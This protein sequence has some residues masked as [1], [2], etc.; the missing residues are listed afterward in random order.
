[1]L[2]NVTAFANQPLLLAAVLIGGLLGMAVE[3]ALARARRRAWPER[4]RWRHAPEHGLAEDTQRTPRLQ[5]RF[6]KFT[7]LA[8][9]LTSV[10][11]AT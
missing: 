2:A 5:S 10:G 3:K 11:G 4:N 6:V 7:A 9:L 1:M 8:A